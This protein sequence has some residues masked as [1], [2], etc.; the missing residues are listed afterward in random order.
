LAA[1]ILQ[2][3]L[4]GLQWL[5]VGLV[6]SVLFVAIRFTAGSSSATK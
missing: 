3:H 2:E 1:I 5:G 4:D 6:I